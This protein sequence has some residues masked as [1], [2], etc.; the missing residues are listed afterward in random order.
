MNRSCVLLVMLFGAVVPCA[1]QDVVSLGVNPETGLSEIRVNLAG[2]PT[3]A[4]PL[5]MVLIPAGAFMMGSPENERGRYSRD[6]QEYEWLP[7]RV[8]ITQPFYLDKH[9]VTQAQWR[10]VMDSDPSHS[11][12]GVYGRGKDFPVYYVSW[13]DCQTFIGRLNETELGAFRLPTEAEWEYACRAGTTTRFSFGDVLECDDLCGSCEIQDQHMWWC[14]NN[15]QYGSKEVGAKLP[16]PWGLFDMHGNLWEWC[17][18]WWQ[19]PT[20]RGPQT[21]PQ[22]PT[23]GQARVFRGGYW[24]NVARCCRSA[25]RHDGTPDSHYDYSP[26]PRRESIGLRLLMAHEGSAVPDWPAYE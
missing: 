10:A 15:S 3:D 25:C 9:E 12:F 14:G 2:L 20:S 5:D 1:A 23:S 7:H 21:D 19:E 22:G 24:L 4:K 13:N 26:R 8:K 11:D 6:G 16:N 18:D 17:S